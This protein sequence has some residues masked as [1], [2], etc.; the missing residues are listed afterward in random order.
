MAAAKDTIDD[1]E[2]R[3]RAVLDKYT[4]GQMETKGM[5]GRHPMAV[6]KHVD[7]LITN[8]EDRQKWV[9]GLFDVLHIEHPYDNSQVLQVYGWWTRLNIVATHVCPRGSPLFAVLE[10]I[11]NGPPNEEPLAASR[12]D[13]ANSSKESEQGK[14]KSSEALLVEIGQLIRKDE[15]DSKALRAWWDANKPAMNPPSASVKPQQEMP[16]TACTATSI[17]VCSHQLYVSQ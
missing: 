10:P 7:S 17:S 16:S 3:I 15:A 5:P 13:T 8:A 6:I 11:I 4:I 14:P 1:E 12:S 2:K 9:R